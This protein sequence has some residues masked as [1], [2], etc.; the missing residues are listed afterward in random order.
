ML[1]PTPI[2]LNLLDNFKKTGTVPKKIN[3]LLLFF[4][5][6]STVISVQLKHKR[7]LNFDYLSCFYSSFLPGSGFEANNS[8]SKKKFR[9]QLDSQPWGNKDGL[10]AIFQISPAGFAQA[11]SRAAAV[12]GAWGLAGGAPTGRTIRSLAYQRAPRWSRS[13]R[14]TSGRSVGTRSSALMK[15]LILLLLD[16]KGKKSL[17]HWQYTGNMFSAYERRLNVRTLTPKKQWKATVS[18]LQLI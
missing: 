17:V 2:I 1:D 6:H 16:Y 13:R 12:C 4:Y 14:P 8:G 7:S 9:I 15:W 11:G 5:K 18:Y 3:Q 10:V